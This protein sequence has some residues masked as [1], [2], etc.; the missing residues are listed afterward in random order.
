VRDAERPARSFV[1]V[2]YRYI[3]SAD[4]VDDRAIGVIDGARVSVRVVAWAAL[5]RAYEGLSARILRSI[6]PAAASAA[7]LGAPRGV[8]HSGVS[9]PGRVGDAATPR[10]ERSLVIRQ[11]EPLLELGTTEAFEEACAEEVCLGQPRAS[12]A[13]PLL[14]QRTEGRARIFKA[15]NSESSV[16]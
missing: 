6:E 13:V 4:W 14:A 9:S 7:W 2:R 11:G 15:A 5:P 8:F 10:V 16:W 12:R 3:S 1:A